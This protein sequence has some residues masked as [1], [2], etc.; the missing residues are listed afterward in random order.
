MYAIMF[1]VMNKS[2]LLELSVQ[3]GLLS[4]HKEIRSNFSS[5]FYTTN[6][7]WVVFLYLLPRIRLRSHKN[8]IKQEVVIEE[9]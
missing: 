1:L 7:N 2:I 3:T 9:L 6:S 4:L 5:F 8:T